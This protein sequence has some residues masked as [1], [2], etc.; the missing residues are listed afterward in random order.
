M[1]TDALVTLPSFLATPDRI[2]TKSPDSSVSVPEVPWLGIA[3]MAVAA[4][5][6]SLRWWKVDISRTTDSSAT[7]ADL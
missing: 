1:R 5:V 4:R 7:P 6:V 3:A 2:V